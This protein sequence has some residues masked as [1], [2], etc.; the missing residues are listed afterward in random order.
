LDGLTLDSASF[1]KALLELT[2]CCSADVEGT[3]QRA[4][5]V[6]EHVAQL[7]LPF[8]RLV[9]RDQLA[10][11][12]VRGAVCLDQVEKLQSRLQLALCRSGEMLENAR[13]DPAW[14]DSSLDPV[15]E[16]LKGLPRDIWR[17]QLAVVLL[18]SHVTKPPL[19]LVDSGIV[20][21]LTL[22]YRIRSQHV[23]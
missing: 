9:R 8:R 18:F 3:D 5:G 12:R 2:R 11:R 23:K 14:R 1:A 21:E 17:G 16:G 10:E 13:I 19:L 7:L 15:N 20:P 22:R 4:V 6:L